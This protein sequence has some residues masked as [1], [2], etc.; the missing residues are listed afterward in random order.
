VFPRHLYQFK[1]SV[2]RVHVPTCMR[3]FMVFSEAVFSTVYETSGAPAHQLQLPA[4]GMARTS[5]PAIN[6]PR[7]PCKRGSRTPVVL[8]IYLAMRP[9]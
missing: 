6:P 3:N 7:T 1:H 2:P 5:I 4:G 9:S 8:A